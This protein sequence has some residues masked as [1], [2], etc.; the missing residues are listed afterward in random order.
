M[1]CYAQ[2][3]MPQQMDLLLHMDIVEILWLFT[4]DVSTDGIVVAHGHCCYVICTRLVVETAVQ[5][6]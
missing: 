3:W 1:M 2:L 4:M 6:H 5:N